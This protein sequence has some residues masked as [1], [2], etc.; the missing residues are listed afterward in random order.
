MDE[1]KMKAL[2]AD[3]D[4]LMM[5]EYRGQ[6]TRQVGMVDRSNPDGAK[7]LT[8]IVEI[9]CE[10]VGPDMSQVKVA[11]WQPKAEALAVVKLAFERLSET[12]FERGQKIIVIPERLNYRNGG[13]EI[14]TSAEKIKLGDSGK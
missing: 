14:G 3:G 10:S 11:V 2:L 8:D 1:K 4:P 13:L 7:V 9:A 5:L 6:A 12:G